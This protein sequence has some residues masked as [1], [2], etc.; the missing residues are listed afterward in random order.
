MI[1]EVAAF[2]LLAASGPPEPVVTSMAAFVSLPGSAPSEPVVT[3][4]AAFASDFSPQ[5]PGER[6]TIPDDLR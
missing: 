4:V 2:E 3:K 1:T 5:L 6:T